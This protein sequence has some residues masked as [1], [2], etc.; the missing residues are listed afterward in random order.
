MTD[1][2]ELSGPEAPPAR[3]GPAR[4]LVVLL[5][6]YG[7]DGNDLIGLAGAFAE[8]AP[9]AA[10]VS[11]HAPD[12]CAAA[13]F[14]RQWYDVWTTDPAERLAAVRRAAAILDRFLDDRLAR[15]GLSE[16][17]LVLVGFSQ[18]TM[19]SLF[20][21][22]R[23]A[24]AAAGIVG[25]SGRIEAPGLLRDEIRSRPPVVLVHGDADELLAVSEM[26]RAA[27]AL[28][29]CGV[30]TETHVR[31]GLGHGIDEEGLRIGREFIGRVLAS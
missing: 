31:P 20:A 12:R 5:H 28:R 22:P 29:G 10:F 9:E 30:E 8:A 6:G 21:A 4:Q 27:A 2:P 11:P 26:E 19:M 1:L 15:L 24:R 13:P 25:Y 16:D 14:G 7:A 17:G 23:R 18:G 3:G